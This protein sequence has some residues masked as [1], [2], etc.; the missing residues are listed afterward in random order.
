[1]TLILRSQHLPVTSTKSESNWW[2]EGDY[3]GRHIQMEYSILKKDMT[4]YISGLAF[5]D[6]EAS[7]SYSV[8]DEG[9]PYL[10]KS[11]DGFETSHLCSLPHDGKK[12]LD[13]IK[14]L[15]IDLSNE[16]SSF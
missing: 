13:L 15:E 12:I 2:F 9:N 14:E 16:I 8:D 5:E 4:F 6:A 11:E 3:K 7:Y 1:M 10:S